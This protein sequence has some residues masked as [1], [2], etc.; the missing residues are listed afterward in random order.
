MT[1]KKTKVSEQ[2]S[3]PL[4]PELQSQQPASP[5]LVAVNFGD[6]VATKKHNNLRDALLSLRSLESFEKFY[7]KGSQILFVTI[8]PYMKGVPDGR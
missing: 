3:T 2:K 6:R 7:G 5:F 4:P 8:S 1:V